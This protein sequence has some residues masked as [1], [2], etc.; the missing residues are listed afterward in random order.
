MVCYRTDDQ[1]FS[2]N[3]RCDCSKCV[4]RQ[5]RNGIKQVKI[6]L[7]RK[8]YIPLKVESIFLLVEFV[9]LQGIQDIA[10]TCSAKPIVIFWISCNKFICLNWFF[11]LV[12]EKLETQLLLCKQSLKRYGYSWRKKAKRREEPRK[13]FRENESKLRSLCRRQFFTIRGQCIMVILF[14]I[15][16]R[17]VSLQLFRVNYL[18]IW[19]RYIPTID[20]LNC[21]QDSTCLALSIQNAIKQQCNHNRTLFVSTAHAQQIYCYRTC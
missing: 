20:S 4:Q 8:S 13:G 1:V 17:S 15:R 19:A 5:N 14:Y 6:W 11:V 3:K 16:T 21:H 2:Y 9:G 10:K 18:P 12:K 7:L